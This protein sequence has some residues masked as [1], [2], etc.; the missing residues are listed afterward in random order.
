MWLH[1]LTFIKLKLSQSQP[2]KYVLSLVL[3][4]TQNG[5]QEHNCVWTVEDISCQAA[6]GFSRMEE[7]WLLWGMCVIIPIVKSLIL[8]KLLQDHPGSSRMKL[9]SRSCLWWPRLD[10]D[11]EMLAESCSACLSVQQAP[12][13]AP[14]HPWVWLSKLWQRVHIDFA[15][16]VGWGDRYGQVHN[17]DEYCCCFSTTFCRIWMTRACRVRQRSTVH[18]WRVYEVTKFL[19]ANE[20]VERFVCTLKL[21]RQGNRTD[22][23]LDINSRTSSCATEQKHTLQLEFLPVISFWD[24]SEPDLICSN[25]I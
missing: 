19:Q 11:L 9:L 24:E 1:Y 21:W 14:L 4:F 23:Q 8:R 7:D 16:H 12:A 15:F 6:W 17:C 3:H 10:L 2:Q 5:W 20:A 18:L 13:A 22:F 25:H